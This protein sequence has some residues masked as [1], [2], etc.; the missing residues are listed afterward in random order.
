MTWDLPVVIIIKCESVYEL[1]N[2]TRTNS[3]PSLHPRSIKTCKHDTAQETNDRNYHQKFNK[4]KPRSLCGSHVYVYR[5][6]GKTFFLSTIHGVFK[7][8]PPLPRLECNQFSNE[9]LE[10]FDQLFHLFTQ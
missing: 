3:I 1:V 6:G 4:R 9:S 8:L 5:R 7:F 10:Y 2:I